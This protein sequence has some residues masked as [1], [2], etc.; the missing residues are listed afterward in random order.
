V[1]IG[2]KTGLLAEEGRWLTGL[3]A[4]IRDV[5]VTPDGQVYLLTD[6]EHGRLLRLIPPAEMNFSK[7]SPLAPVA[8]FLGDWTGESRYTPPFAASPKPIDE[9]SLMSCRPAFEATYIRCQ[10]Q[11]HRTQDGRLRVI[12]HDINHQSGKPG[13]QVTVFDSHWPESTHYALEWN[14]VEQAWMAL[15]PSEHEGRSATER[16]VVK[17][18]PDGKKILHTELIRFDDRPTDGWTETFSWSWTR[19]PSG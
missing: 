13:F 15:M 6:D 2:E 10:I 17:P 18:S 9:T 4:R 11:F 8:Y 12:E 3:K 1:R 14:G 19:A 5:R 7:D 16:I